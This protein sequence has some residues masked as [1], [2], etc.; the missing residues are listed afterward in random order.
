V[1]KSLL[2]PGRSGVQRRPPRTRRSKIIISATAALVLVAAAFG[3]WSLY[4]FTHDYLSTCLNSGPTVVVRAGG[5]CVG[6][7]DGSYLFNPALKN[8]ES[9]ILKEDESVRSSGKSYET[10]A[11]LLPISGTGGVELLGN[12]DEQLEGAYVAQYYAN[13]N[14]VQGTAPLIQL[15]IASG[16]TQAAEYATT[17]TIIESDVATQHLVAVAGIGTSLDTTIS[18]VE[19]LTAD[20]IPVIGSTITSDAFDNIPGLV[21]ISPS[22]AQE[23]GAALEFI[24]PHT[25]TAMLIEDVNQTDSYDA[26]MVREFADGFPDAT[27]RI[28]SAESYNSTND[29][30]PNGPVAQQVANRIGQMTTDICVA[31]PGVVLFAGRGTDL[32]T[33]ISDLGNRPCTF[34]VTILTG[35]GPAD[36]PITPAVQ[37]A[38]ADDVTLDYASEANPGEWNSGSSEVIQQGRQGFRQFQGAFTSQFPGVS[39]N[40]GTAMLGYDATLTGIT[41]IR[42]AGMNATIT[43]VTQDLNAIQGSRVVLGASGPITLSAIYQGRNA[44]GSNPTGKVI[45]ILRLLPNG[46][47]Q[48]LKLES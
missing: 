8:V 26:T 22:N 21:R 2:R 46:T 9:A 17:N 12:V 27:H 11:Y 36:M 35:D 34:P 28:I 47:V 32:S 44:Q 16:G 6:V 42:L 19:G 7:T 25:T 29:V 14:N 10:V 4:R 24:K 40:D 15:L 13:R 18:E 39:N 20:G 33:L 5:E 37:S 48:F 31:H 43:A 23:V 41:V 3:G 38:L 1:I 30:D 45:P